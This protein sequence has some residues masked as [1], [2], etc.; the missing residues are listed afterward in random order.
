MRVCG[1]VY[2]HDQEEHRCVWMGE[3][4]RKVSVTSKNQLHLKKAASGV[5]GFRGSFP[6]PGVSGAARLLD[7][8]LR[9][10][11]PA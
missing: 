6:V 9:T 5:F 3:A 11:P 8:I 10:A 4:L 1:V 2:G 7:P